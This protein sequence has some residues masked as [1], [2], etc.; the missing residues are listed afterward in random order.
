MPSSRVYQSKEKVRPVPV[1]HRNLHLI[2]QLALSRRPS[3]HENS[4]STSGIDSPRRK[5]RPAAGYRYVKGLKRN[6][7]KLKRNNKKKL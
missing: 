2:E 3:M 6:K 4:A 5:A 1:A 7:K